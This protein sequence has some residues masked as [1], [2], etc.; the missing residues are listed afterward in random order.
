MKLFFLK[1]E[2]VEELNQDKK[3]CIGCLSACKFSSW[4]QRSENYS[5]NEIPDPRTFCIQKALQ[6][7]IQGINNAKALFFSGSNGYRFST[8]PF[9]KNHFI[10]TIKELIDR[11]LTGK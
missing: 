6:N 10:P 2:T 8:D 9:Y 11:I 4:C 7:S 5:T 3:E 1:Q